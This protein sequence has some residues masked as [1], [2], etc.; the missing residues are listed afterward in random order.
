MTGEAKRVL[1]G[2]KPT[3]TLHLGNYFGA[4]R[5]AIELAKQHDSFLFLAD[6]H[7]LTIQP[8]PA[9]LREETYG[10]AAAWIALGV[11]PERTI[12]YRQS[13]IAEIPTLA[14]I[15]SCCLPLGYLNR[16][17]SFK[18]MTTKGSDAGNILHGLYSY[19]VLMAADIL[20]FAADQVP[21][22]KDQKQHLE[23]AQEAARKFNHIYGQGEAILKV[24]EALI[25]ERVMT[26][27][28]L[29]G[30]KMS[31]SYGNT[32]T[33]FMTPKEVK[34]ALKR[35]VTDSTEYGQP[36]PTESDTILTLINLLNPE[37]AQLLA[38]NYQTGRKDPSVN[39]TSLDEPSVN[40]FGWGDAKAALNEVL[41]DHF[42]EARERYQ[43]LMSDTR[44]LE[45]LL[46][47]GAER[48]R[49]VARP[50]LRRVLDLTGLTTQLPS[51]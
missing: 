18:D 16:A 41:E 13:D 9:R 37:R 27:P 20:L 3:G 47:L 46:T 29:D 51:S 49:A 4:I 24:P 21:V 48:A 7:A 30:R 33:P 15:L 42:K 34:K 28:G 32:L 43:E 8:D 10:I 2:I 19:P 36:L 26:I 23:I 50:I 5:P 40:Y 1:T 31:K 44:K 11:D 6:L 14:W 25:D 39:D 38:T 22:G 35:L 45:H 17:H 12:F